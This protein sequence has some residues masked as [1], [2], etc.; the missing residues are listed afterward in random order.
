[1]REFVTLCRNTAP[2]L[3]AASI[4]VFADNIFDVASTWSAFLLATGVALIVTCVDTMI[5]KGVR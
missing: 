4:V 5:R 2:S 1:M 3:V